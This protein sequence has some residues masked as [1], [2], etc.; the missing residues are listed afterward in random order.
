MLCWTEKKNDST[1]RVDRCAG[2]MQGKVGKRSQPV[3]VIVGDKKGKI[4]TTHEP[5]TAG[6]N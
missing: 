2:L 1:E 4:G 3:G 5:Y 6:K